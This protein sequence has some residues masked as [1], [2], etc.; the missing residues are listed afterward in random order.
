MNIFLVD[1]I[2]VLQSCKCQSKT[3]KGETEIKF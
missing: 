3:A 2:A 1:A